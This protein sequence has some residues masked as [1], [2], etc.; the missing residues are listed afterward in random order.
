[1]TD[2]TSSGT[3]GRVS[4]SGA[5]LACC[6]AAWAAATVAW[7]VAALAAVSAAPVFISGLSDQMDRQA[8]PAGVPREDARMIDLAF[9]LASTLTPHARIADAGAVLLGLALFGGAFALLRGSE[10]GRRAARAMLAVK[11]LLSLGSAAWLV[12]L[13]VTRLDA[14]RDRFAAAVAEFV[15][16]TPRGVSGASAGTRVSDWMD[17][18]PIVFVGVVATS[19]TV[20][21]VLFWLAGRPSTRAWC[22]ARSGMRTVDSPAA[23]R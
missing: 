17:A 8:G 10:A 9:E 11:A 2:A 22:A 20:T 16:E 4:T 3:T 19:L 18:A 5:W 12:V 13:F 6:V 7:H 14:W 23:L 21:A 1:M 15:R